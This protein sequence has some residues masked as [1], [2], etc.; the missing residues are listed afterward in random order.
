MAREKKPLIDPDKFIESVREDAVPSYHTAQD[1]VP[2][3]DAG[4][5]HCMENGARLPD[6]RGQP[7]YSDTSAGVHTKYSDLNMT[8]EEIAFIKSYIEKRSFRRVNINGKTV[9]INRKHHKRISDILTL[10]DE[11]ANISTYVDNVLTEHFKKY[12]PLI[13]GI[14]GKCP[15]KF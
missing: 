10:F 4:L 15:P 1:G 3:K 14:A 5:R 9:Q 8:A 2:V 12:Y 13:K 6:A 7:E 11:D